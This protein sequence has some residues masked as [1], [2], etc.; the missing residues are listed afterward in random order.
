MHG[1]RLLERSELANSMIGEAEMKYLRL[2]SLL[3]AWVLLASS[4]FA[5][6]PPP[7]ASPPPAGATPSRVEVPVE[8]TPVNHVAK[9][10]GPIKVDWHFKNGSGSVDLII[11]PNGVYFF[12]VGYKRKAPGEVLH[13]ELT[14]KTHAGAAYVFRFVGDASK[15]VEWSQRGNSALFKDDFKLFAPG[16][17]WTGTYGLRLTAEAKKL[18]HQQQKDT[19]EAIWK[20]IGWGS[21]EVYRVPKFCKQYNEIS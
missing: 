8:I 3:T 15:G 5:A 19:C 18:L 11:D 4:A 7:G 2:A 9:G 21:G 10:K 12:S 14:L 16:H 13:V 17:D 1:R 20:T 6:P